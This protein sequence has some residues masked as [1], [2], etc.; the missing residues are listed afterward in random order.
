VV[1]GTGLTEFGDFG[2]ANYG[3]DEKLLSLNKKARGHRRAL[4]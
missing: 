2:G 4:F 3:T 1:F